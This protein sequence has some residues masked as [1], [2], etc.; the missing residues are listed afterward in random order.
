LFGDACARA[1]IEH[2]ER[3]RRV[4]GTGPGEVVS[5]AAGVVCPDRHWVDVEAMALKSFQRSATVAFAPMAQV[6]A[7]GT[8]AG[9]I[10]PSFSSSANLE[11]LKVD[12]ASTDLDMP[13]LSSTGVPERFNRLSWSNVG[14]G[15]PEEFPLGVIAGGLADGS[16]HFWNPQ[17]LLRSASRS[18]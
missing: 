4:S 3:N 18:Q 17:K 2:H 14:A 10:D 15:S 6:M 7:V 11:L 8:M 16:L 12:F 9:A 5:G 13:V 1:R